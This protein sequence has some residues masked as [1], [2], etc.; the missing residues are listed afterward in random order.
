MQDETPLSLSAAPA[1]TVVTK[2]ISCI[3]TRNGL[4]QKAGAGGKETLVRLQ[5]DIRRALQCA[6]CYRLDVTRARYG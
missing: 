5:T 4:I 2:R 1:A 6:K 3:L